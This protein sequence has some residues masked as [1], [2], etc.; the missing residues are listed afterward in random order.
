MSRKYAKRKNDARK[1]GKAPTLSL[2]SPRPARFSQQFSRLL[3]WKWRIKINRLQKKK[4]TFKQ[5]RAAPQSRPLF[6]ELQ[7]L[8]RKSLKLFHQR[9]KKTS[10]QAS[11]KNPL[12]VASPGCLLIH[13]MTT[14]VKLCKGAVDAIRLNQLQAGPSSQLSW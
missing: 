5:F 4:L 12:Y 14:L 13:S 6:R 3:S 9:L 10:S 7:E 8:V 11:K 1:L 2:L